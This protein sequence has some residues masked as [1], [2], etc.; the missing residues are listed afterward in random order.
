MS[1]PARRHQG[2]TPQSGPLC[3]C[4]QS[5]HADGVRLETP[6]SRLLCPFCDAVSINTASLWTLIE[7]SDPRQAA[8]KVRE[9]ADTKGG[10]CEHGSAVYQ[11][12]LMPSTSDRAP[13][14]GPHRRLQ[15]IEMQT[16]RA[17]A[18]SQPPC[19]RPPWQQQSNSPVRD[20]DVQ[21]R[22]D[23]QSHAW[24]LSVPMTRF[25]AWGR[26]F[27]LPTIERWVV[28]TSPV[29]TAA[30]TVAAVAVPY[31]M[32]PPREGV[33][34]AVEQPANNTAVSK[35]PGERMEQRVCCRSVRVL[36]SA[37]CCCR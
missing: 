20:L 24:A 9:C 25:P 21:K 26:P 28:R 2:V 12:S 31:H 34:A 13:H 18:R 36:A 5:S 35:A 29:A 1:S 19:R 27:G 23:S 8:D 10:R 3:N 15:K 16:H 4:P 22:C 32:H 11:P 17:R 30:C 7:H 6:L 14:G 37:S 33:M